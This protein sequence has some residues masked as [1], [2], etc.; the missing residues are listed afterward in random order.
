MTLSIGWLRRTTLLNNRMLRKIYFPGFLMSVFQS[1]F[2]MW[3]C[4]SLLYNNKC[5]S[6]SFTVKMVKL[7]N[8]LPLLSVDYLFS[9]KN[10]TY[11]Q[12][13]PI[14]IYLHPTIIC[15]CHFYVSPYPLPAGL[16]LICSMIL[17]YMGEGILPLEPEMKIKS[18]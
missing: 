9:I 6:E 14:H 4:I 7:W 10:F 2:K 13:H 8:K 16:I 3:Q 12:I 18:K 15:S 5:Y 17:N 1:L 11:Q